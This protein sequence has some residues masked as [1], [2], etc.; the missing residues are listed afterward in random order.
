M[1]F[2]IFTHHKTLKLIYLI[3]ILQQIFVHGFSIKHGTMFV[4]YQ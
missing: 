4:I 2:E 3:F 1:Y